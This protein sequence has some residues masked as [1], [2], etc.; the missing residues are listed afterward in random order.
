[1]HVVIAGGHGQ[2]AM[3]LG[4]LLVSRGEVV[5]GLI[6]SEHQM[7]DLEDR[8]IEATV[9]DLESVPPADLAGV[10]ESADAVVFAAGA[11]PGSGA[12]RKETVDFEA[13]ISLINACGTAGVDRYVMIS[14]MGAA[15]PPEHAGPDN[16]F[17]V[18]LRAKAGA[19]DALMTSG[20]SWTVVR[21]GRL[22]DDPGTGMVTLGKS[23]DRGDIPRADVAA[24]LAACLNDRST[25]GKVFE[26]VSGE[27][28]ILEAISGL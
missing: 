8:G 12:E 27:I 16:V 2:V 14:A 7:G 10:V 23:V 21:P 24:V 3:L 28:P 15:K 6:R 5:T 11:G 4:E 19:D 20:L 9:M 25:V 22:T 1:M 18:Y 13:A 17:G 26:V